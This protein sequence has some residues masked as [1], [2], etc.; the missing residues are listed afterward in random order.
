MIKLYRKLLHKHLSA[1]IA[2]FS[3]TGPCVRHDT[4]IPNISDI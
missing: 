4:D 1:Y 3:A 2:G